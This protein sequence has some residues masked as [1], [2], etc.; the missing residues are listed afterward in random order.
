MFSSLEINFSLIR[1]FVSQRA[2]LTC[3]EVSLVGQNF[4][5][6]AKCP[7]KRPELKFMI[8]CVKL[9]VIN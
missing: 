8:F 9:H 1:S 3:Q 5:F 6:S 2:L 7:K 4:F